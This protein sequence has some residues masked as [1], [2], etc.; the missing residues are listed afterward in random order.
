VK[1]MQGWAESELKHVQLGDQ[2]LNRRLVRLVEELAGQPAESVPQAGGTWAATKGAYRFWDCA[3]VTPEDIRLGHQQSTL[4]RLE[5]EGCVLVVQDTTNLD[6]TQRRKVSGLGVLDH[7]KQ[8]GIKVHSALTVSAQGVPLGLIHQEVWSR[9]PQQ[10]GKKQQR[11]RLE[12]REKESQKWLNALEATEAQLPQ[13]L[14]VVTIGDRES[15]IYDLMAAPRRVGSELLLRV[16]HN[17]RVDHPAQYL[18][19]AL[20]QS[21]KL[22]ELNLAVGGRPNQS[23]RQATLAVKHESLNLQPPAGRRQRS[24]LPPV[25]AHLIL[26]QEENPPPGVKAICWLLL[27]TWPVHRFQEARQCLQWYSY[28]WLIERYHYVLKSG[29]GLEKLQLERAERIQRALATYCIVAWRLLWLTYEARKNPNQPC[30]AVFEAGEWQSLY[31]TLHQGKDPPEEPPSLG[32]AVGWVARLGGFLGRRHDGDPG[33]KTIW[34]GLRRLH[35]IAGTWDLLQSN[36]LPS[37]SS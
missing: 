6:F 5:R 24:Q 36:R 14:K 12:T 33:V 23:P 16:G 27:S 9:D 32:Q 20:A 4:E 17:R 25:P 15:D 21:P 3:R 35:D 8:Q 37:A 28:R 30:T 1:E 34:R 29:C 18:W 7:P 26:A 13:G 11:H 2:R 19:S 31:C 22:G 10:R